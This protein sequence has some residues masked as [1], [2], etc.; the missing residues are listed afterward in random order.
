MAKCSVCDKG[1]IAGH[2]ISITRS[3]VSRRANRFWKPNIKKVRIMKSGN[4]ITVK[5]CTACLRSM[6]TKGE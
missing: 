2:R 4:A 5:M 1:I 6:K 3:H